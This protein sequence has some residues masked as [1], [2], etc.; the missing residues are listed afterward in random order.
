MQGLYIL[1]VEER[2]VLDLVGRRICTGNF[3][4][5]SQGS[6]LPNERNKRGKEALRPQVRPSSSVA[7]DPSEASVV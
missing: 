1:R 7:Y 2:R 4:Y 3:D 6:F 5:V